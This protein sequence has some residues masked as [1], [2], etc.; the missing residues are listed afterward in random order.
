MYPPLEVS[1]S[2]KENQI[3]REIKDSEQFLLMP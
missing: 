3:R 2:L 1:Q